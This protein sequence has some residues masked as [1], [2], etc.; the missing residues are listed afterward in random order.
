MSPTLFN[1]SIG[2]IIRQCKTQ[3][4]SFVGIVSNTVFNYLMQFIR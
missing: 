3:L 2:E 4:L 1:V